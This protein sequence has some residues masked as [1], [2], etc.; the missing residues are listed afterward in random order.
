MWVYIQKYKS[1]EDLPLNARVAI[2]NDP[3]NLAR[4]FNFI[5]SCWLN[6]A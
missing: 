4:A 2:P 6:S 1:L 5:A 3:V